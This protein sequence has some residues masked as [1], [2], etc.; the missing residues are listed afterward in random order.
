[1][2]EDEYDAYL[3]QIDA[4]DPLLE[5]TPRFAEDDPMDIFPL[6]DRLRDES[7]LTVPGC[8]RRR[9]CSVPDND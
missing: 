1:M 8:Y 2:D 7:G 3:D 6:F 4:V 5:P 9:P